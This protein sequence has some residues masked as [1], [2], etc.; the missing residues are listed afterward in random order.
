MSSSR[1]AGA[2][3]AVLHH[4]YS[5]TR[6]SSL[7]YG[8][9]EIVLTAVASNGLALQYVAAEISEYREVVLTA[10]AQDGRA[11]RYATADLKGEPT[12]CQLQ[13]L[14]PRVSAPLLAAELRLHF[15]YGY[16]EWDARQS[17]VE[18]LPVEVLELIGQYCTITTAVL[19]LLR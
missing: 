18:C 16:L 7:A 8:D 2:D 11:L 6:P 4:Y 10:V 9:R 3:R 1:G 13:A 19:G 12:L 5:R 14:C 17:M 15:V